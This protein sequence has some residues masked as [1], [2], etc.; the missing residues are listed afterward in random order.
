MKQ[1]QRFD[2]FQGSWWVEKC[3]M[4]V[5][6]HDR[7]VGSLKGF[8]HWRCSVKMHWICHSQVSNYSNR[9]QTDFSVYQSISLLV[10]CLLLFIICFH[11]FNSFDFWSGITND[12]LDL[13]VDILRT[14]TIPLLMNF[15]IMNITMKVLNCWNCGS[16]VFYFSSHVC[17]C[18][19]L[20]LNGTDNIKLTCWHTIKVKRRGCMPKGG[21]L[22][23][24]H[25]PIV[26]SLKPI[27]LVDE[28]LIKK[29]R[30]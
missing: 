10:V 26:R 21:G 19:V 27:H 24:M 16:V 18:H 14:V 7:L 4:I 29:V 15:G 6:Y 3:H 5:D 9:Y 1:G 20:F 13:S 30:G 2:S 23:E 8:C 25:I 12:S 22:V 28:G 11:C 17:L